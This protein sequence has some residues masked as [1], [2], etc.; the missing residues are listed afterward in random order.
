VRQ[1]CRSQ[2]QPARR[3]VKLL[4]KATINVGLRRHGKST[5]NQN[6]TTVI[7]NWRV[8]TLLPRN[9]H[10]SRRMKI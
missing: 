8:V 5:A 7:L 6:A 9:R 1:K 4:T 10:T 2:K 3:A